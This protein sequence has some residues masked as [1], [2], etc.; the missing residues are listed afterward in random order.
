M[1]PPETPAG[2]FMNFG[3]PTSSRRMLVADGS[4]WAK[5]VDQRL[6][7]RVKEGAAVE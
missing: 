2:R 7:L 6:G 4:R 1:G 3:S 5:A